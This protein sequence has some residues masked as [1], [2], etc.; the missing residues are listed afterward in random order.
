MEG[1]KWKIYLT[2]DQALT[3]PLIVFDFEKAL[4]VGSSVLYSLKI[5]LFIILIL[6]YLLTC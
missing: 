6:S 4:D 1:T 3:L 2:L 5:V